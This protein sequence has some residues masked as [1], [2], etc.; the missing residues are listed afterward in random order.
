LTIAPHAWAQAGSPRSSA[1]EY[2]A[3]VVSVG[4]QAIEPEAERRGL[5]L[6]PWRPADEAPALGGAIRQ[7]FPMEGRVRTAAPRG[8]EEFVIAIV[9]ETAQHCLAGVGLNDAL[10]LQQLR[11]PDSGW[12]FAFTDTLTGSSMFDWPGVPG[13]ESVRVT[14]FRPTRADPIPFTFHARAPYQVAPLVSEDVR[15]AW[16]RHVLDVCIAGAHEGV[17]PTPQSLAPYLTDATVEGD[18]TLLRTPSGQPQATQFWVGANNHTCSFSAE[19]ENGR[20]V[21]AAVEADLRRRGG[22]ETRGRHSGFTLASADGGGRRA[23]VLLFGRF[24]THGAI[25]TS[26]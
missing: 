15:S 19:G 26:E 11:D 12:Q 14:R 9:D 10:L 18:A 4:A 21:V 3:H 25:V 24:G 23:S 5:S 17:L 8:G 20:L 7:L 1:F 13:G 16:V 22:V 6:G 2:C